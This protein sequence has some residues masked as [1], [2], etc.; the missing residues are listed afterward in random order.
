MAEKKQDNVKRGY[1]LATE[2]LRYLAD[3]LSATIDDENLKVRNE[4]IKQD[5]EQ[6]AERIRDV[7]KML[8]ELY[9]MPIDPKQD[10]ELAAKD[11]VVLGK[12][13]PHKRLI[14]F[15]LGIYSDDLSQT[16]D[17]IST[18]VRRSNPSDE[19]LKAFVK[20]DNVDLLLRRID[21]MI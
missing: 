8:D 11:S 9:S 2:G 4:L 17:V 18:R 7:A 1:A 21:D 20:M 19:Y 3:K 15:A 14:C 16:R 5:L 13:K 6:N 12:V 10:P